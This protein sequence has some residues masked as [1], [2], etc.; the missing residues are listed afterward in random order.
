MAS[1]KNVSLEVIKKSNTN[2]CGK[3]KV[4][5]LCILISNWL[6]FLSL[7]SKTS[8]ILSWK[9]YLTFCIKMEISWISA[10]YLWFESKLLGW[11]NK[12]ASKEI[13]HGIYSTVIF[14]MVFVILS[15]G[16]KQWQFFIKLFYVC[17][18]KC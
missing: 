2:S 9:L 8:L 16:S 14:I 5:Y 10:I 12:L 4:I 15:S 11:R 7:S 17:L 6:S 3:E 18:K 1:F 13:V